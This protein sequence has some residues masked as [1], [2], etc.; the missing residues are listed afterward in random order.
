[1]LPLT[2]VQIRASFVNCSRREAAQARAPADLEN[3]PWDD[4]DLLGWPDRHNPDR[5]NLVLPVDDGAVGIV[6]RP[7]AAGAKKRALCSWC[8]D[9]VATGNVRLLVARRAGAAGRNGNSI[10]VLV[11][12]D[13]SCSAH[14]RRPPTTLEGGVDAEAMVERRVAELRSRTRAFAEHVRY[15]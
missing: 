13:L 9:V 7:A 12:D 4:L 1:M 5:I 2:E 14:V 11:H 15:G 8:E 6:L 3:L 10:G